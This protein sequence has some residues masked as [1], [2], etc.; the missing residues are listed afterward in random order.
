[1]NQPPLVIQI[2]SSLG[3]LFCLIAY[4]GH[5]MHWMDVR[6]IPY[7]LFNILGSGILTYIAFR[8]FQAG[9]FI[10]E[11]VWSVVSL[12]ALVKVMRRN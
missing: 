9:F 2:L 10:M 7:S 5:Q 6:K 12:F 4:V 3:A 11:L 8:P 1:M